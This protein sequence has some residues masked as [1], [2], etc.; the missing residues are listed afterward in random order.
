MHFCVR[1]I[2]NVSMKLKFAMEEEIVLMGRMKQI[3]HHH[4]V[5][6]ISLDVEMDSVFRGIYN[7]TVMLTV[8]MVQTKL[9]VVSDFAFY[10]SYG[11]VLIFIIM[12]MSKLCVS[13]PF[14]QGFAP[15]LTGF[16][17]QTELAYLQFYAAT[18]STTAKISLMSKTVLVRIS[19]SVLSRCVHFES[20]E[21]DS[22]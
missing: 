7:V 14:G 13:G 1:T 21:L 5:L 12:A 6:V 9:N 3:V 16:S 8:G 17:A 10:L 15:I 11:V 4:D 2:E 18:I 20:I 19:K 22:R